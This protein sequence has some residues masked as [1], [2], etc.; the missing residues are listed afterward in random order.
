MAALLGICNLSKCWLQTGAVDGLGGRMMMTGRG[1]V[2][3][4]GQEILLGPPAPCIG[5]L[6]KCVQKYVPPYYA[7]A[8]RALRRRKLRGT[9]P[10]AILGCWVATSATSTL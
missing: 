3:D 4:A 8:L 7:V 1:S 5:A 6:R 2:R 9:P 10:S